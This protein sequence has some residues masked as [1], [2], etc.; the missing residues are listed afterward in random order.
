MN[1]Q[2]LNSSRNVSKVPKKENKY[3]DIDLQ[4]IDNELIFGKTSSNFANILTDAFARNP[5]RTMEYLG[6]IIHNYVKEFVGFAAWTGLK[7]VS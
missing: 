5:I 6:Q 4:N 1:D 7:H 3:N 2:P